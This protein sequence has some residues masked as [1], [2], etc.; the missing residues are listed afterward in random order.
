MEKVEKTFFAFLFSLKNFSLTIIMN[1]VCGSFYYALIHDGI[2]AFYV[3]N[4]W[5]VAITIFVTTILIAFWYLSYQTFK[6]K[7]NA[8][9]DI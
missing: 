1:F 8:E 3:G 6:V 5:V 9:K 2:D 4:G 7:K